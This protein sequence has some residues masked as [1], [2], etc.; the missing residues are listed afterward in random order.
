MYNARATRNPSNWLGPIWGIS[1]YM[2]FRGLMDYGFE[3]DAKELVEKMVLLFGRDIERFGGLHE[4]YQ[5]DNGEPMLNK[6]FR[7]WNYLVMQMIAWL[8]G[9]P[10]IKEF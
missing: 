4:Y 7:N 3:N 6:G 1:N 8:E 2:T 5:P 10:V 9:R